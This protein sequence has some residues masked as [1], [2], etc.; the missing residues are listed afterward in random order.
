[1]FLTTIGS[2]EELR[3][4]VGGALHHGVTRTEVEEILLQ[5]AGYAGYPMAMQAS[6]IVDEVFNEI[7][8]IE[9]SPNAARRRSR[10]IRSAGLTQRTCSR[11][12]SRAALLPTRR[13]RA[14]TSSNRSAA[15]ANSHSTGPS[16]SSGRAPSCRAATAVS[17]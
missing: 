7:D 11:R 9:R 10:T 13:W 2:I 17:S 14:R 8:G 12:C 16:A 5:V 3:S 4:H 1:M 6:R 15:S